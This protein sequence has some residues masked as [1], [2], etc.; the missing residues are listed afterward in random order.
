MALTFDQ[1]EAPWN[2]TSEIAHEVEKQKKNVVAIL[3]YEQFPCVEGVTLIVRW[4]ADPRML[5][6]NLHPWVFV[7]MVGEVMGYDQA[8]IMLRTMVKA[9][10]TRIEASLEALDVLK[11]LT[12]L[13]IDRMFDRARKDAGLYRNIELYKRTGVAFI[14][15]R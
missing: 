9:S 8:V 13:L 15:A 3:S 11:W 6:M 2:H 12:Y 4:D 5:T 14:D 10:P 1:L 7:K